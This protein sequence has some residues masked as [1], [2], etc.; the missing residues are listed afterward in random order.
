MRTAIDLLN[1]L[2][3]RGVFIAPKL[4]GKL[5]AHPSD[6]LTERDRIAI[7]EL[8]PELIQVLSAPT[9]RLRAIASLCEATKTDLAVYIAEH[10]PDLLNEPEREYDP[11][12]SILATCQRHGVTLSIG[13]GGN[14]VIG[15]SEARADEPSQP[16]P[17]LLLAIE[18][19]LDAVAVLVKAG[20]RLKAEFPESSE[21]AA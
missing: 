8:K 12:V 10:A 9:P 7:R 1:D 6:L 17:S 18:A 4:G 21:M 14:L 5:V 20:W 15:R 13:S 11:A 3:R 2:E 16:W 19:H